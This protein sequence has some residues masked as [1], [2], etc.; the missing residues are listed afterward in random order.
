VTSRRQVLA[1]IAGAGAGGFAGCL[2]GESGQ[3]G[4]T[5]DGETQG[6]DPSEASTGRGRTGRNPETAGIARHGTP[7]TIC[8]EQP[9]Q[10]PGIYAVVDPAFASDWEGHEVAPGYGPELTDDDVVIGV[11]AGDRARAYPLSVLYY[12]EVVND[13]F[14]GPLLVTF[15]PL[16]DSGMVAERRVRGVET[17]FHVSG[18]LWQ[19]PRLQSEAAKAGESVF[20]VDAFSPDAEMRNN[21]NLVLVDDETRSY[22]SQIL[23]RGLCGPEAGTSLA[24]R[25]STT[26]RWSEWRSQHPDTDVLLPPP[27]SGTDRTQ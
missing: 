20:G 2:G 11:E 22:W 27:H 12:H 21:G 16:C 14:G 23:A 18:L 6:G 8:E 4:A 24:I 10:D 15:C 26:A 17:T 3:G 13:E 1:L 9:R 19:A 7:P 5:G 25:A